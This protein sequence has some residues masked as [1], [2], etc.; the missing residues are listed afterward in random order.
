MRDATNIKDLEFKK[1]DRPCKVDQ[2]WM[3]EYKELY[4][5]LNV[6]GVGWLNVK[7]SELGKYLKN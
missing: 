2:F 3:T 1:G 4:V 7:A 6:E 5:S